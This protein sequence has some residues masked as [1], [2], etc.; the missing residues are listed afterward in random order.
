[1]HIIDIQNITSGYDNRAVIRDIS[2]SGD[3][4]D[5]I[6]IIGANGS[7]K[8][9]L[10]KT[11]AGDIA[12]QKG[13]IFINEQINSDL[14]Q[15]QRSQLVAYVEQDAL[16]MEMSIYEYV[17]MGRTPFRS[18]FSLTDSQ[19]DREIVNEAINIVGIE[20]LKNKK[21]NSVS[22]GERRLADIAKAVAQCPKVLLLD[23]PTANLD[24]AN[25][26]NIIQLLKALAVKMCVIIVTHDVN[27]VLSSA[28]KMLIMRNGECIS[29]GKTE[30]VA[31]AQNLSNAYNTDIC[32][33]TTS[34][35][36]KILLA[37]GLL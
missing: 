1:M 27:E 9:T 33:I 2:L 5:I 12:L 18:L 11:I 20:H 28:N 16:Q 15:R 8:S 24:L 34:E 31:N 36:K 23:E 4:G 17:M 6:A 21:L 10:L 29:Y 3:I 14:K 26:V 25:K 22:G 7:G 37:S 35:G 13:Q 32:E 19:R 30:D